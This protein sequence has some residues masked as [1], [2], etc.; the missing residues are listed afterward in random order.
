MAKCNNQTLIYWKSNSDFVQ[1]H[2]CLDDCLLFFL[3][4]TDTQLNIFGS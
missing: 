4:F 1:L 2:D 3:V